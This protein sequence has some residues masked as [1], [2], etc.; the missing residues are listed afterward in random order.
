VGYHDAP[1]PFAP[2]A[3]E[4][5]NGV[6]QRFVARLPA[7]WRVSGFVHINDSP[8]QGI[9]EELPAAVQAMMASPASL[10]AYMG[11]SDLGGANSKSFR[12]LSGDDWRRLPGDAPHAGLFF[13]CGCHSCDLTGGTESFGFAA[14]RA[15][16]GPAA[17]IGSQGVSYAAMGTLAMSGLITAL[18]TEPPPVR[19]G[20]LWQG[21]QSGLAEGEIDPAEFAMMDMA[22]GSNGRVPLAAQRLEHLE[23]WM[24]LGDPAM[25]LLPVAPPI[26]LKFENAVTPGGNLIVTGQLPEGFAGATV[27]LTFERHPGTRRND[28]PKIAPTGDTRLAS[29]RERRQLSEQVVLATTDALAT[30]TTFRAT[31]PLPAVLPTGPWTLRAVTPDQSRGAAGALRVP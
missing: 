3:D 5:I 19:L 7:P 1:K 14:M 16:G 24:L 25:P 11:H 15:P 9:Y 31:L 12:F 18:S 29:A 8:W 21:V 28:L 27:R 2:M 13:S 10:L 22:D 20:T 17:V 26:R 30:G 4:L 23:A 6:T